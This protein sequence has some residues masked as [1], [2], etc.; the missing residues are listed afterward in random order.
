MSFFV[1]V[2]CLEMLCSSILLV[3]E[4][5]EERLL[6]HLMEILIRR[7]ILTGRCLREAGHLLHL[8]RLTV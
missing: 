4:D 6:G 7:K 5:V 2:L 1:A 8:M 3:M